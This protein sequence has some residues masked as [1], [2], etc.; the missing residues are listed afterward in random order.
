MTGALA[1]R[2]AAISLAALLGLTA[3]AV[4]AE[5][6]AAAGRPHPAL[7]PAPRRA[8]WWQQK[9]QRINEEARAAGR[10]AA[11]IFVGDSITAGWRAEG[12]AIWQARYGRHRALNLGIG[13]DQTGHVLWRLEHGNLAGLAPR[14]AVVL[15]GVNNA[16]SRQHSAAQIAAGVG[17]VVQTLRRRLPGARVL[18]LGIFPCGQTRTGRLRGKVAAINTLIAGLADGQ[19]VH[20]LD[21]GS[22]F[23]SR[24]GSIQ[25]EVMYDYLHLTE[26]GYRIWADA[27][28]PT[29]TRLLAR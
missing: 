23:M 6:Q 7:R 11:L 17:A 29:L 12:K 15:I 28:T 4:R 19:R 14:L 27:M 26:R 9:H 3:P 25:Q 8:L 24:D 16:F 5:E 13:G 21:L 22:A 2:L 20:Y 10:K 1:R 18:V